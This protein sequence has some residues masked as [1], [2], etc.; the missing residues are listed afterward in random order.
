MQLRNYSRTQ[1]LFGLASERRRA[2]NAAQSAATAALV[3]G[4][5]NVVGGVGTAAV[6]NGGFGEGFGKALTNNIGGIPG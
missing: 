1:Q 4:I 2:S 5:S 6:A 3:G